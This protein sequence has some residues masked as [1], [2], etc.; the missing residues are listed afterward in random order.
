MKRSFIYSLLTTVTVFS[1][2]SDGFCG[3]TDLE[4]LSDAEKFEHYSAKI[5]KHK[6]DEVKEAIYYV[7]SLSFFP[8]YFQKS[9]NMVMHQQAIEDC[10]SG[11][12]ETAISTLESLAEANHPESLVSL[13]H[14]YLMQDHF[15]GRL[16]KVTNLLERASFLFHPEADFQLGRLHFY[17]G[18]AL[19]GEERTVRDI[20]RA[21]GHFIMSS[22]A[23]EKAAK[24]GHPGVKEKFEEFGMTEEAKPSP[25]LASGNFGLPSEVMEHIR[26]YLI[27]LDL[28]AFSNTSHAAHDVILEDTGEYIHHFMMDNQ[29]MN[30]LTFSGLVRA[31]RLIRKSSEELPYKEWIHRCPP[32]RL[33]ALFSTLELLDISAAYIHSNDP[34]TRVHQTS[35]KFIERK[36]LGEDFSTSIVWFLH[37]NYKKLVPCHVD[38]FR[39]FPEILDITFFPVFKKL[40]I[41]FNKLVHLTHEECTWIAG[42][43]PPKGTIAEDI[44]S[45]KARC[46]IISTPAKYIISFLASN[47]KGDNRFEFLQSLYKIIPETVGWDRFDILGRYITFDL[48]KIGNDIE[49]RKL[50]FDIFSSLFTQ[51]SS[52]E[53]W[54]PKKLAGLLELRGD[55]QIY[56]IYLEELKEILESDHNHEKKLALIIEKRKERVKKYS[57]RSH[58][59]F[60]PQINELAPLKTFKFV[61]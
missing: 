25:A 40:S 39:K 49:T 58:S 22:A 8:A 36:F 54:K 42:I 33:G 46:T 5:K 41:F 32:E 2:V 59:S 1:L 61:Y 24:R 44:Y 13:A 51:F 27:P 18:K 47:E 48:I 19:Q 20:K 30:G 4:K 29:R 55:A 35:R 10:R 50:Y 14:V 37:Q 60:R 9:A 23:F 7:K 43:I 26:K 57:V 17:I 28:L 16:E 45:E 21:K 11:K 56:K 15:P 3:K 12:I 31:S 38:L 53:G 34:K 52:Q 6:G